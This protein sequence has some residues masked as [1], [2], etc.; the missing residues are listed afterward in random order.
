MDH[1]VNLAASKLGQRLNDIYWS[2]F[3]LAKEKTSHIKIKEENNLRVISSFHPQING[4]ISRIFRY[5]HV[6]PLFSL[7]SYS[8]VY[9]S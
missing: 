7:I 9:I 1:I 8:Y 3:L 4:K 2:L 6:W 5:M